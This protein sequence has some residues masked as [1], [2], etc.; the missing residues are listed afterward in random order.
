MMGEVQIVV[1]ELN[2]ELCAIETLKI[3]EI[4]K[5]Q[6]VTKVPQLPEFVEGVINLR[7][8]VIPVINL[9]KRF[10]LGD[11][12]NLE[13][14]KIIVS[15]ISK[16]PFAFIVNDVKE[17]VRLDEKLIEPSPDVIVKLG[18]KYIKGIGKYN[19]KLI[20]ILNTDTILKEDELTKIDDVKM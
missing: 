1:F 3:Q 9:N 16:K 11:C 4:I 13:T 19:G 8:T 15:S 2:D 14:S 10:E 20:Y 18:N 17:I 5:Y 6:H 12:E 7:E